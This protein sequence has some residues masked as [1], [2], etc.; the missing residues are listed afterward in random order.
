MLPFKCVLVRV[1]SCLIH[2]VYKCIYIVTYIYIW[3]I[4]FSLQL[5]KNG[6]ISCTECYGFTSFPPTFWYVLCSLLK[7]NPRSFL[8]N[9]QLIV[10]IVG[11]FLLIPSLFN[12]FTNLLFI[13]IQVV[14]IICLSSLETLL[15]IYL[16]NTIKLREN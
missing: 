12:I 15:R 3:R 16:G 11:L 4:F 7:I 8:L 2:L 10:E 13:K 5:T 6:W 1:L 9:K 14:K